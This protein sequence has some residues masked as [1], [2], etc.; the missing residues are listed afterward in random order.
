MWPDPL[1]VM[2]MRLALLALLV[3]ATPTLA[4]TFTPPE[5]CTAHLTIQSR[6]CAV[7]HFY[8]CE[9]D[10]KGNQWRA[11]FGYQGQFY[12][13][14]IDSETQWIKSFDL[15]PSAPGGKVMETLDPNPRDPASFNE[16][17]E[18]GLDSFD[19]NL[20]KQTGEKT[21]V[22]GFDKLTGETAVIDGITL[23]QTEF[24]YTQTDAEGTV[25]RHAK[26]H[27]FISEDFRTFLS[28][29]SEWENEDGS[30][31]ILNGAPISFILPGEPGFGA[32]KPLFECEA[33]QAA[34]SP[35][36]PLTEDPDHDDL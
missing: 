14:M 29:T 8:T 17:V 20:T 34:L 28:G 3:S 15:D 9:A 12:E 5:G 11:D 31:T 30:W 2:E 10:P 27:E 25:L 33:E 7:S 23:R 32:T 4:G 18:T 22:T 1:G 13:S 6:G 21:R 35:D 36:L 19:F 26:G 24:E 16:L